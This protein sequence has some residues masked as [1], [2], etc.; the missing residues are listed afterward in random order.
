MG[1]QEEEEGVGPADERNAAGVPAQPGT[2]PAP[3]RELRSYSRVGWWRRRPHG[4][5]QGAP[6]DAGSPMWGDDPHLPASRSASQPLP[7]A[8]DNG[9]FWS[10]RQWWGPVKPG[11]RG[12]GRVA[13]A[14]EAEGV[15]HS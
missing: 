10:W 1:L 15:S 2:R 5:L 6:A 8:T 9:K 11:S 4:V 3:Q 13:C 12:R 14:R 7:G